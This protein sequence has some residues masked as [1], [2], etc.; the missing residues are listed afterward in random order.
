MTA[1]VCRLRCGENLG[2]A[3]ALSPRCGTGSSLKPML[4]NS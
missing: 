2:R 4:A 3:D 1:G